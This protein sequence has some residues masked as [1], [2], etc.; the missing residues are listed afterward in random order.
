MRT[1]YNGFVKFMCKLDGKEPPSKMSVTNISDF[2]YNGDLEMVD[3]DSLMYVILEMENG[4]NNLSEVFD[5]F[6]W[7]DTPQG[8]NY[9]DSLFQGEI[10]PIA[11]D[12]EYCEWLL[13]E[14][15]C[16]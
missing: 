6:T 14:V 12:L 13:E 5:A 2:F 11:E 16:L 10:E 9:W 7:R 8:S 4:T 15:R 1:K 3:E